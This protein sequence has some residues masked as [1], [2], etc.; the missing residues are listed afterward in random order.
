MRTRPTVIAVSL[1]LALLTLIPYGAAYAGAGDSRFTGFL[2]NPYDAASYLAKMRQGYNGQSLYTLAFTD[3]PGPG[4]PVFLYYLFLGRL[5]RILHLALIAVW[6]AARVLGAAGFLIVLWEFLGRL[7]FSPRARALAWVLAALGSGF[8]F[9]ALLFGTYTA[10]LWVAEYI[11]FLGIFTSAHFP[12]ATALILLLAMEIALPARKQTPLSLAAAFL[13]GMALGIIQPFAFLPLGA[14]LAVWIVWRRAGTGRFPEGA[15]AGMLAAGLGFL[16]WIGLDLWITQALPKFTSWFAQNQTPTPPPWNLALSLGVPGAVVTVSFLGW[17][18][19]KAPLGEKLRSV[20][21]ATLLLGLWLAVNL[22]LLYAP[23]PLQRR[24]MLGMWIPLAALAAPK[25]E[26]WLFPA[27]FSLRRGL[28][29]GAPA[30][31][32]NAAF[33]A[34][35]V[36]AGLTRNP[37]LFLTRDEAATADWLE[38]NARGSVVLAPPRL[39]TWL[40]GM[41]GVRVVYGHPMETPD[42]EQ[43]L[44]DVETFYQSADAASRMEILAAHRVDWVV[45]TPDGPACAALESGTFRVVFRSGSVAILDAVSGP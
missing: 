3:D 33:L 27:G 30:F 11:P 7:A 9:V 26:A 40:P 24:L 18:R 15:V 1:V 2:F 16:P 45:C 44:L 14:A 21:P 38:A 10:D 37:S 17:L 19:P 4:A 35:L 39:S 29:A 8:G 36:A 42:A 13:C 23:L 6:Q 31:L 34:A 25:L 5:A 32:T 20:S 28:A 22:V 12:A 41:A 43:A